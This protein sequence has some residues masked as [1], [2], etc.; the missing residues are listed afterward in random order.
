VAV[1]A[2]VIV[3]IYFLPQAKGRKPEAFF[4]RLV[5][6]DEVRVLPKPAPQKRPARPSSR[7]IPPAARPIPP[8]RPKPPS[9]EAPVVPGE[10]ERTVRPPGREGKEGEMAKPVP[11]TG[12]GEGAAENTKNAVESARKPGLGRDFLFDR[13]VI[14]GIARKDA[15]GAG[16]E[17]KKDDAVTFDTKDFRFAGYMTKLRQKIESIWRYPPE[18]A[19]KGIYGDLKI[20]FTIKKDGRLGA[21]ELV[22]T[23]GYRVLDEAAIKALKDGEPY[24]PLPDEWGK[25]SYTIVGHF[26]YTM[27]GYGLH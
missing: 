10:G 4:A 8:S 21:V 25:D 9:P 17:A 1:H 15:S 6:P 13:D 26:I 5:T 2:A 3:G 20:R 16:G 7:P 23:S 24:W 12:G 11:R 18:A 14:A 27:Y 19:E 22:R